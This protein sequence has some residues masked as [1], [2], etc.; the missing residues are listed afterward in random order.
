MAND[1]S[2]PISLGPEAL[3]A[4]EERERALGWTVETAF[5]ATGQR[6]GVLTVKLA[7][8]AGRAMTDAVIVACA[9]RRTKVAQLLPIA[10]DQGVGATYSADV[11]LP[12]GGRWDLRLKIAWRGETLHH[13]F[14]L[15]LRP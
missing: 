8:S 11:A 14:L 13:Q 4:A 1:A 6:S 15:D 2:Q 9:E 3:R 7:D 12:V 10:F 5:A